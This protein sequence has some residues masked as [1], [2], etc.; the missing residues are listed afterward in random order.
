MTAI[1][2]GVFGYFLTWKQKVSRPPR[3]AI[4]RRKK[5]PQTGG[6]ANSI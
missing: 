6:K 1:N 4:K 2:R 3:K 5:A